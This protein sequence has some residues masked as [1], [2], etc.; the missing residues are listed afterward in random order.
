M[1]KPALGLRKDKRWRRSTSK[2]SLVNFKK[3]G[4]YRVESE[5]TRRKGSKAE[6]CDRADVTKGKRA[7]EGKGKI[8]PGEQNH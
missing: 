5:L 1:K 2:R 6:N 8:L 7:E 4:K 3:G